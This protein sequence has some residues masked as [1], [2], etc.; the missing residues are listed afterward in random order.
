MGLVVEVEL[1]NNLK[2][3]NEYNHVDSRVMVPCCSKDNHLLVLTPPS[4]AMWSQDVIFL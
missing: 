2:S 1:E 3:V 4:L